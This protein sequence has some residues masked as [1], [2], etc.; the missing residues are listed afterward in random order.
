MMPYNIWTERRAERQFFTHTRLQ[1]IYSLVN[2]K[3]TQ[4]VINMDDPL[5]HKGNSFPL[6]E[7]FCLSCCRLSGIMHRKTLDGSSK[8]WMVMSPEM[9]ERKIWY[10]H[11]FGLYSTPG[12]SGGKWI[13]K[14]WM[15]GEVTREVNDG[16]YYCG[17]LCC[18]Y[19]IYVD[20]EF[21]KE[22]VM[23][24]MGGRNVIH[25]RKTG[26][27]IKEVLNEGTEHE[28]RY[29]RPELIPYWD[30]PTSKNYAIVKHYVI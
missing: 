26:K 24:G 11:Q 20:I 25:Y 30:S 2:N 23:L 28:Y 1:R 14:S 19:G 7:A 6:H 17:S 8:Y 3:A 12:K 27:I 13:D 16:V 4:E 10:Q 18:K 29:D 5:D 22:V 9:C 15:D 21:P